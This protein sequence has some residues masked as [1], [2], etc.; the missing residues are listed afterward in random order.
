[1]TRNLKTLGLALIAVLVLGAVAASVAS[2]VQ[3]TFRTSAGGEAEITGEADPDAKT[4]YFQGSTADPDKFFSCNKVSVGGKFK[5]GATS[6]TTTTPKYEECEA[7]SIDTVNHQ[8]TKVSATIEFTSCDYNFLTNT[9][10]G[11]PTGGEHASLEIKCTTAGDAIHIKVTALKIKCVTIPAQIVT[12]AVRY[13]NTETK[14]GTKEI[15]IEATAHSITTTTENSVACPVP[16][17]TTVHEDGLYTGKTTVKGF[18]NAAHT[19]PTN[20]FKE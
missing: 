1:M 7:T 19:E 4:Q 15:T 20:I 11:N 3:D 16:E 6:I 18:K 2:A 10:T 17:G 12:H 14:A 5:D 13:N 8:T 9:T